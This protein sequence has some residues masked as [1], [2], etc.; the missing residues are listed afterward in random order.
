MTEVFV[1]RENI[2]D[3]SVIVKAVYFESGALIHK[4]QLITQIETSK[5]NID[6]ESPEDGILNH[7]LVV[8][9]EIEVG[10][11]LFSVDKADIKKEFTTAKEYSLNENEVKISKAARKRADELS[12]PLV[13]LGSGWIT[14]KDVEMKSGIVASQLKNEVFIQNSF[15]NNN[16]DFILNIPCVKENISK[17]KQSEIKNLQMGNHQA[18]SSTIG[19]DIKVPG[20]R[21]IDPPFL[22]NNNISDLIVFEGSKLLRKY[23]ELNAVYMGSKFFGKYEDVNFGWS[24]DGGSNLKVLAIKNSDKMSLLD[25]HLEVERLLDLYESNQNIPMDLLTSST[26]TISDLS[27]T[28]A[29]FIFP[30]INGYQSLILGVV[31]KAQNN[32]SI[33]A[34]FDH[35]VSEGL[36]VTKFLT[37]LKSRI[38]SYFL[39]KDGRANLVCYTCEKSMAEELSLRNRGFIKITLPNG[40]DTNLCR[41]C[42]DGW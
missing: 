18:T 25:L 22:F 4:G 7:N 14:V 33:Y 21:I 38:L 35:R 13:E 27:K 24:F 1:P 17:R 11:F 3:D 12:I 9:N 37:E 10:M 41:T 20:K 36:T 16:E 28:D 23:P 2:N 15:L 29:T 6:I 42:F 26:V 5:T 32:F 34:T 31:S 39:D 30:L 8:E 40:D 19:I